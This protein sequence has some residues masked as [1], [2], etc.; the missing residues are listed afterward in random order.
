MFIVSKISQPIF[1]KKNNEFRGIQEQ[2]NHIMIFVLYISFDRSSNFILNGLMCIFLHMN[3]M[4]GTSG[5]FCRNTHW[6]S[7]GE[8]CD[9]SDDT[10]L[11]YL[12]FEPCQS[13]PFGHWVSPQ[14][15]IFTSELRGNI[16]RHW[17]LN[18]AGLEWN[19]F[20]RSFL[21][22][23]SPIEVVSQYRDPQL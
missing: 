18:T 2:K 14:N 17:N 5:H 6:T 8:W 19:L 3:W 10:V 1:C 23:F 20:R 15:S 7:H 12:K 11:Q 4:N 21:F 22:K 9:E 13:W 16:L